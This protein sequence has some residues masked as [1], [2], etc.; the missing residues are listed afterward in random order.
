MKVHRDFAQYTP[1]WW[2]ARKGKPSASR[3]SNIITPKTGKYSASATEYI[4][5]LLADLHCQTPNFFTDQPRSRDMEHGTNCEPE[6]R[7]WYAMDQAVEVEEVGGCETDDG[8][9][10]SSPDGLIASTQ[11]VLELKCPSLKT[12]M[13]YLRDNSKLLMEYRPQCHWHLMVTG[14]PQVHLVSYVVGAKP[15]I[16]TVK[17]DDF[18][19]QLRTAAEL[20]WSDYSAAIEKIKAM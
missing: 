14:W 4:D 13:G 5:E 19:A 7:A 12:H 3:A 20:F 6:A 9:F 2:E 11:T 17:P 18:T 16:L 15:L 10:W 1:E 8:R